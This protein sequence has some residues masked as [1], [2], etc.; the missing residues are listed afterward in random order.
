LRFLLEPPSETALGL[1]S[2]SEHQTTGT[3]MSRNNVAFDEEEVSGLMAPASSSSSH[4]PVEETTPSVGTLGK[5]GHTGEASWKNAICRS[6]NPIA[7]GVHVGLKAAPLVV[8]IFG[9]FLFSLEYV[10]TVV[11]TVILLAMDA[12][13]TK[14]ITGRL[15][16]GLRYWIKVQ[17]DGTNTF[18][19]ESSNKPQS[20]L[21]SRIFW[22]ALYLTPLT[23][24][25][26]GFLALLRLSLDWF[27]ID[28]IAV[29]I[30]GSSLIGF[31][32]CSSDA[33]KRLRA[34][35][36]SGAMAGLSYLPSSLTNNV[37]AGALTAAVGAAAAKAGGGAGAGAAAA[38][39]SKGQKP[40]A[41]SSSGSSGFSGSASGLA[42]PNN[43]FGEEEDGAARTI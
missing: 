8:Y 37:I 26:F 23:W 20:P 16:V 14:N 7:S 35:L 12:W 42:D 38:P 18:V 34:T 25:I 22:S 39:V 6:K 10:S 24:S 13:A 1:T 30:T 21:D 4:A 2:S 29:G 5:I 36:T 32:R 11:L 15:M 40:A 27:L 33:S 31:L 43:P 41:G 28:I 3:R 9:G 19:F 17:E